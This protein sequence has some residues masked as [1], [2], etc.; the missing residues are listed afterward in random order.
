MRHDTVES[1]TR[2]CCPQGTPGRF[3]ARWYVAHDII[4]VGQV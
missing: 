1:T 4:R 2:L 3:P